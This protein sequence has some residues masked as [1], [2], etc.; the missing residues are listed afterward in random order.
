MQTIK[1]F[2]LTLSTRCFEFRKRQRLSVTAMVYFPFV[3]GGPAVVWSDVGMW[4]FLGTQMAVPVI[5]EGIV[6]L[7]P[8]FLVHGHAFAPEGAAEACAVRAR[9]GSIEKTL[10]VFG[11]RYWDGDRATPPTAF[12]RVPLD[13]QHAYGGPDFPSNPVGRGR[14]LQ[15]VDG[16]RRQRLPNIEDPHQRL[17]GP[18]AVVAPA[19][20]GKIEGS[21]PQRAQ[22]RGTYDKN[23]LPEH[24]PGLAPDTNWRHF[25]LAADDQIFEGPLQGDESFEFENMHPAKPV[26]AGQLPGLKTRVYL[27]R[28]LPEGGQKISEVAMQLS[29]L[30]FFPHSERGVLIFHGQIEISEPDAGDVTVMMGAVERVSE[31]R[32][33]D[34]YMAVMAQR[35]DP[36]VGHL[37]ALR[38]SDLMPVGVTGTDPDFEATQDDYKVEGLQG[39]A[40]ARGAELQVEL[41]REKV[42]EKGLDPDAL[43]LKM[44]VREKIPTIE[45]LPAYLEKKNEE[46]LIEQHKALV[47]AA[48]QIV[49]AETKAAEMG[50]DLADAA[51]GGPP[52]FTAAAM[53]AKL[54]AINSPMVDVAALTPKLEQMEVV[55]R[56]NYLAG[57]H[58]Q[59]PVPPL[60]PEKGNPLRRDAVQAK[61]AGRKFTGGNFT[62]ADFSGLDFSGVDFQHAW[63]ER[64][65]FAGANLTGADFSFAVLAHADLTDAVAT[66]AK[67]VAANLGKAKLAGA[68]F[69][70]ADLSNANLSSVDFSE[71][72]FK[73]ASLAHATLLEAKF[74]PAD[75]SHAIVGAALFHQARIDGL[76]FDGAFL[77]GANFI[78][79][80]LAGSSFRSAKL[81][82]TNFIACSA[83]HVPFTGADLANAV[84]TQQCNLEGADFSDANLE[85]ANLRGANMK[86]C[87][88]AGA[89]L[90]GADLSEAVLVGADF[91]EANAA[92]TLIVKSDL[93]MAKAQGMNLM[94]SIVQRSDLR[95]T[96]FAGSNLFGADV[97]LTHADMSTRFTRC[98]TVRWRTHPRRPPTPAA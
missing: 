49:R 28:R 88:F 84:F 56:Y 18:R 20:F 40:Q 60:P 12:A 76:N 98:Y 16:V 82:A 38:D 21:W 86:L 53:I 9:V 44:P 41:M 79:C 69:D 31:P 57:A 42:R 24:A 19:G 5:D 15:D 11:N 37:Y 17:T 43:G 2:G 29:T 23:W 3:E 39:E 58:L 62:G 73:A 52:T 47:G 65:N 6:K 81:S 45:E 55:E 96:D 32:D 74:G 51:G 66:G 90:V 14:T 87:S 70:H 46:A 97:S 63:L 13:W 7:K 94:Q 35:L 50:I 68:N 83:A 93:S 27:S 8:E 26:V 78:E 48:Q 72:S 64:V 95:G 4:K 33:D 80:D 77:E 91:T 25:N 34:H 10:L 89:N 67:F 75:W 71:T 59:P 92:D 36:G 1:P 22:F 54:K 61:A 30:W 85:K